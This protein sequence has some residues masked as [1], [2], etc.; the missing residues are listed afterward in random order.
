MIKESLTLY[1]PYCG[2]EMKDDGSSNICPKC[3]K[4]LLEY[5]CL[6]K[7]LKEVKLI[8]DTRSLWD[9][10]FVPK[11][12]IVPTKV[13]P[14]IYKADELGEELG[15]K[16]LYVAFSGYFPERN[17]FSETGTFKDLEAYFILS[18]FS[19]LNDYY[20]GILVPS[21]GNTSRAVIN[22]GLKFNYKV[23]VVV[24]QKSLK[25]LWI[26]KRDEMDEKKI[27]KLVK[28]ITFK[29]DDKG[30]NDAIKYATNEGNGK[31][32]YDGGYSNPARR[33]GAGIVA[34]EFLLKY[35]RPFDY[36]IQ[37]VGSATGP[38]GIAST[39]KNFGIKASYIL[40][41]DINYH[42]L[43]DLIE[44]GRIISNNTKEVIAEELTNSSPP[45]KDVKK[46]LDHKS[47]IYLIDKNE[48]IESK[49]LFERIEGIDIEIPSAFAVA[50]LIKAINDGL[51]KKDTR[52]LLHITGGGIKRM[53][54]DMEIIELSKIKDIVK[55][56]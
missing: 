46:I 32:W 4:G 15:L 29:D 54:E 31:Y 39:L 45:Y 11:Y 37:A 3:E 28:I 55:V 20:E 38:L 2:S 16:E 6:N 48:F 10:P 7:R 41:Q 17:V 19:L 30:Y 26:V 5:K 21:S 25:K 50:S 14:N 56:I 36:Y 40:A 47:R 51:V 34:T 22:A 35:R 12:A 9:Y 18:R 53:F 27:E 52:V 13:K 1:C 23:K 42:P 43:Y 8:N 33:Y 24:P 44:Y 49:K